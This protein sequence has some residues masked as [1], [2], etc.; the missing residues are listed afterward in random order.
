MPQLRYGLYIVL[1]FGDGAIL[2]PAHSV[3][4]NRVSMGRGSLTWR[5]MSSAFV[6][7]IGTAMAATARSSSLTPSSPNR[8]PLILQVAAPPEGHRL[9]PGTGAPGATSQNLLSMPGR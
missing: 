4:Q 5:S 2:M 8:R 7:M 3:V 9:L 6:T 1:G